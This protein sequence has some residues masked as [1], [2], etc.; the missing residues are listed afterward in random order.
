MQPSLLKNHAQNV[1]DKLVQGSFL[2]KIKLSTSL[3][4]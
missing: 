2:K 3:D 4:Q 1:V